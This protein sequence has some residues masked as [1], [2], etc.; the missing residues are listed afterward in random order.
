ML[1]TLS[2]SLRGAVA[3]GLSLAALGLALAGCEI[4]DPALP[5]FTTQVALPLG[6]ER[7]DIADLVDDEDYLIELA[8]GGLGFH[9]DGDPDTVSLDFDL[10]T[11]LTPQTVR[12][13][14]G[15]FAL[16]LATP[17]D[18]AFALVDLYPAAGALDGQTV[19]V[20]AFTF[21][22]A[23]E[24]EDLEDVEQATL[25][26]GTLTVTVANALPVPVSATS[27]PDRLVLDL[28]DPGDGSALVSFAFDPI[29]PGE[30]VQQTAD[31]AGVVLPGA[32]A[33]R[34]AGG[35]PG[36]AGAPVPV[37]AQAAIQVTA[38]FADLAV[39]AAVAAVPAQEFA[40]SFTTALPAD[41]AVYHA[42]IASGMV[43]LA[44]TNELAIPCQATVVWPEIVDL[45][46][47][48][49]VLVVDLPAGGSESRSVDLAGRIVRASSGE[50]LT[51]L[52]ATLTVTSPGSQGV[53]VALAADQGVSADLAGGRV[54]FAS[55]TGLVPAL[56]YAFAPMNEAIDL[57][58]ELAGLL[59]TRASLVLELTNT[60][61][62]P[63]DARFELVGTSA[64]GEERSLQV[65]EPIAPAELDRAGVTR[66][67]LDET[68]SDV[69]DF[70]NNLPT[71][72]TLTGEVAL[73]G[74]GQVGTVHA[75]DCAVVDWEIVAP[76]DVIVE[77]SQLYGDPS[78]LDLDADARDLIRDHAGAAE[79][80][81]AILNHLPLGVE[82][83]LLFSPDT[84]TIQDS[85]LL[86]IGPVTVAAAEV[87]PVT[88]EVSTPRTSEPRVSLTRAETQVLAT[89]G[90]FSVLEVTLPTTDG[91]TVRVMTTDYVTVQGLIRLDVE[92]HDD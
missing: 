77:S 54:E 71:Q 40:T 55:I 23:S 11:D 2:S 16:E 64:N 90:L 60:A 21:T 79:I 69:V 84:T 53:P 12:G 43:S 5:T 86:A 82:T 41:Y 15:A 75:G 3:A 49:V 33:V 51:E 89:A 73:G 17:T 80:Q 42:V 34:L 27:G 62:L 85:P 48:P 65:D 63:A 29:G 66:I 26:A 36:S 81:L 47:Q 56:D 58:E 9:V 1:R 4:A 6:E 45:D 74:A 32:V 7:L 10:G 38:T 61:G 28:V 31:L 70:L 46:D 68:N 8:D 83:R 39:T 91:Q 88:H 72:I 50:P 92:V 67:V 13:E 25:A 19:P 57:P 37:D 18:F 30:Q 76:V 44:V 59:L 35:S 52:A 87:D 14:L 20:P 22:A 24:A 78:D